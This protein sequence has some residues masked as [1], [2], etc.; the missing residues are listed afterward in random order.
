MV[1]SMS[2]REK[3]QFRAQRWIKGTTLYDLDFSYLVFISLEIH[4]FRGL[5]CS[6][7]FDKKC[8]RIK[9]LIACMIVASSSCMCRLTENWNRNQ[10]VAGSNLSLMN[11]F[12]RCQIIQFNVSV[13]STHRNP[14]IPSFPIRDHKCIHLS[15]IN[16]VILGK[17]RM[18]SQF[19]YSHLK[20]E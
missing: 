6:W 13:S 14:I 8:L 19:L 4:V 10:C 18:L 12:Y 2:G 9:V 16:S 20:I 1:Q 17:S 15:L 7:Y 11:I 3:C 5:W